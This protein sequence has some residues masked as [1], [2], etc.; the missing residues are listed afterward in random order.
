MTRIILYNIE[1]CE[2]VTKNKYQ[3]LDFYHFFR[4]RKQLDDEMIEFLK[5]F[6]PDILA[7]I[8][9]DGGGRRSSKR[10]E[11]SYFSFKLGLDFFVQTIKYSFKGM[12]RRLPVL[13]YQENA[14]LSKYPI[15]DVRY[16]FLTKGT[17][18]VVIETTIELEKK[19]TLFVV[20]L[21]LFKKTRLKQL[22]EL[23]DLVNSKKGPVILM[24]D[25]NTFKEEELDILLTKTSLVDAYSSTP[26]HKIKYTEPSWKPKYR[27][28]NILVT[29]DIKIVNYEILEA[30]F[31]DHLPVLLDF[32]LK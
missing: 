12:F 7:L 13:R 10:N 25:F 27:L 21:A 22:K 26:N 23:A 11:P 31:S 18:K 32:E 14:L 19:V 1:Y 3:Y 30:H 8:E 16:H 28:D 20:H 5:G 9:I 4:S 17:K 15:S 2:G 29:P 6:N 24:G